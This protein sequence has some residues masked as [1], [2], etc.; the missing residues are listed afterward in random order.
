V[1]PLSSWFVTEFFKLAAFQ[2]GGRADSFS[3]ADNHLD[4]LFL[5]CKSTLHLFGSL[6]IYKFMATSDRNNYSL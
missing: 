5:E 6:P 2:A 1:A 4:M 3:S